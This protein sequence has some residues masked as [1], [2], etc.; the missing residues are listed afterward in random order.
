MPTKKWLKLSTQD[1]VLNKSKFWVE[2][3]CSIRAFFPYYHWVLN[4]PKFWVGIEYSI[5]QFF[6]TY[7]VW[8][9]SWTL[10]YWHLLYLLVCTMCLNS[11]YFLSTQFSTCDITTLSTQYISHVYTCISHA[12]ICIHGKYMCYTSGNG[13]VMLAILKN[14]N[15]DPSHNSVASEIF[16]SLILKNDPC[17]KNG[18]LKLFLGNF[19]PRNKHNT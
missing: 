3:E 19:W 15:F 5:S 13:L 4:K 14:P 17:L 18:T 8:N 16:L 10:N 2:I 6:T 9:L 1:W 7:W 11:E 12:N